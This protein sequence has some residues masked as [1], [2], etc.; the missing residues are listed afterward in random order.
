MTLDEEW[1]ATIGAVGSTL[2]AGIWYEDSRR[3]LGRDWHRILDP[4]LTF[5]WDE[6]P[7]WQQ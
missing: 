1:F 7:Y 5:N 4:T 3:D 2:R 6:R